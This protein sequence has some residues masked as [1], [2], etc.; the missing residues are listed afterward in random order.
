MF[1]WLSLPVYYRVTDEASLAETTWY[2]PSSFLRMFS[3]RLKVFIFYFYLP[4]TAAGVVQCGGRKSS[5]L[6]STI[7]QFIF[8]FLVL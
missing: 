7:V 6:S 3:L 2:D 4:N 5:P 8:Y 1:I